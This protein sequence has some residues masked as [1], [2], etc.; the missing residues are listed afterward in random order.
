[1]VF[2]GK[3]FTILRFELLLDIDIFIFQTFSSIF[4]KKAPSEKQHFPLPHNL[5][6]YKHGHSVG[7][8]ESGITPLKTS[9]LESSVCWQ[10]LVAYKNSQEEQVTKCFL[11][12]ELGA[13]CLGT[14]AAAGGFAEYWPEAGGWQLRAEQWQGPRTGLRPPLG[15]SSQGCCRPRPGAPW[16]AAFV[17]FFFIFKHLPL[18]SVRFEPLP[19][20][21]VIWILVFSCLGLP[22]CLYFCFSP[23]H[24]A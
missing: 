7:W 10:A 16:R 11:A 14:E 24:V 18:V 4:K 19:S 22:V 21:L 5:S 15:W 1:M 13:A 2:S 3:F 17:F 9:I 20:Q 8:R 12:W 23:C 6:S